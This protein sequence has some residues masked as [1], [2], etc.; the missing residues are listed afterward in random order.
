MPVPRNHPGSRLSVACALLLLLVPTLAYARAPEP[1]QRIPLVSL[2]F[3]PFTAA[4]LAAGGAVTTVHFIDDEHLLVT[5]N[6]RRL[7]KRLS[8]E[9]VDDQDRTVEAVLVHLP[10]GKVLGRTSWRLH[11]QQQYLWALGHGRF[12]LRIRDTLT[13]FV[14]LA[15]L[16]NGDPFVEQPFLNSVDRRIAAI[17][18]SPD[19][20]LVTVETIKRTITDP[21]DP[22]PPEPD[23]RT[24]LNFYRITQPVQPVDQVLV[25][26]AGIA[27]AREPV[28][29]SLT[30]AGY[31]EVLQESPERWLF[32][33]DPYVGTFKELSPFD[34]TCRPHPVFVSDAEFVAIGCRGS[35]DKLDLGGFNLRGEQMW[36]Q[37]FLDTHAF[38]N[39][40]F[41]PAAGRFAFSRNIVAAGSGITVDF[42]PSAFTTQ[43]VRVYQS[44]TGKQL[45]QLDASPVQRTGQNYDLSADGLRLAII[46]GEAV[47]IHR[48]PA[49]T[50]ADETA[51]RTVATLKPVVTDAPV[52]LASHLRPPAS[53]K[54]EDTSIL[55]GTKPEPAGPP[56]P[57]TTSAPPPLSPEPAPTT[58][59]GDVH[60]T[61]DAPRKPPTLYTLPTDQPQAEP[62]PH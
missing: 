34:T 12:L 30:A 54:H 7:M 38:P 50:A 62:A 17:L 4:V 39:F 45:L 19:R 26:A 2:G 15:N 36:Q 27:R 18:L 52:N 11:D 53:G 43:Q 60:P 8:D 23:R 40:A 29:L 46:R 22:N 58:Q 3:Q 37:N 44:T 6:V 14:P 48:L 20:D 24:Q 61:T 56:N 13:T 25:C 28:D 21:R 9:P 16:P 51:L 32:D 35:S 57:A 42:A 55:A 31:I 47:E 41:A 59:L 5:F 49:L 1:S 33:F 10:S